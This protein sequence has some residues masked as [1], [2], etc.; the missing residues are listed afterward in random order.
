MSDLR[1]HKTKYINETK[2]VSFKYDGKNYFG[3][4][5]DTLASALLANGVHLIGRSFKYHRPRGIM[6]CGSEEPNAICQIS[7]KNDLLRTVQTEIDT[8][9]NYVGSTVK[10]I[11]ENLNK[12]T[13]ATL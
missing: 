8:K 6:S 5:G 11:R 13:G 1:V 3:Y 2:R 12:N 10:L 9:L 4:E 7:D